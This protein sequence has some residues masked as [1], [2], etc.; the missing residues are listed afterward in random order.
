MLDLKSK[1]REVS[2]RDY[3]V[4][5]SVYDEWDPLSEVWLQKM[6]IMRNSRAVWCLILGQF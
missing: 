4:L 2:E 1:S 3:C 6:C 5:E